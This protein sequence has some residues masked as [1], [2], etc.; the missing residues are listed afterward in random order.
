MI[1]HVY[2]NRSNIGDWLAARGIQGLLAGVPLEEHLCDA[3]FV[4]DTLATLR[5]ASERDL[6][7]IGG[8]G[9][10]MDY[11]VPF[12][13]G[14]LDLIGD[15]TFVV[16][17]VGVCDMKA[18]PT[19]PDRALLDSIRAR[20]A[21]LAVRDDHT[22]ALMG[23][24]DQQVVPCP[25]MN[26]VTTTPV[27]GRNLLY[28]D[29]YDNI[30]ERAHARVVQALSAFAAA[31]DRAYLQTDNTIEAGRTGELHA[32]LDRYAAADIIVASR[33]HGCILA[34]ALGRKLLA[35]SGDRK[36]EAFMQQAGLHEWVAPAETLE[37]LESNL[38]RLSDQPEVADF[39][40]RARTANHALAQSVLALHETL[41]G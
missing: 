10:F 7:V 21:M 17:G 25:A 11:F 19:I 15:R 3:P 9:L 24:R 38:W 30:G 32:L 18:R 22:R 14:F 28:A 12:W 39:V 2:A 6:I 36:V 4:P 34:A 31:T 27:A 16:W 23:L 41:Q 8:G 26:A 37:A 5:R 33:L 40:A 29:A 1:H 13:E 35:I 20:A